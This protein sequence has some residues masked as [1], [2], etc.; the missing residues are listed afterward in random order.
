MLLVLGLSLLRSNA[1]TSELPRIDVE[2][3]HDQVSGETA[4]QAS[5]SITVTGPEGPKGTVTG[6]AEAG[7]SFWSADWA[8][9]PGLPD[10]VPG[11]AVTVT[12]G[13]LTAT[14]NPVGT[15]QGVVEP[16]TDLVS[17]TIHAAWFEPLSLTVHC[18]AWGV[19][20]VPTVTVTHVAAN[21]GSYLCDFSGIWDIQD[22]Q[23]VIVSYLEPDGDSVANVLR[24]RWRVFFPLVLKPES[25]RTWDPR[26]DLLGVTLDPAPVAPGQGYWRLVEA[27]WADPEESAGLHHIFVDVVD[28]SGERVVGQPVVVEWADG[29]VTLYIEDKPPPE[30]GANFPMGKESILGSH[31]V[32]V[33]GGAPSDRIAGLGLGTPEEPDIPHHTSFYLI[34]RWVE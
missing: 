31:S 27:L 2:Y 1:V 8:W 28:A 11:D 6:T 34:F 20:S 16:S 3:G 19:P 25:P 24:A 13:G 29:S 9:D 5:V 33:G 23:Q 32:H 4:P 7:G 15:I 22:G 12:A 30:Y 26:L 21:G 10:I 17:G 14:V 18:A